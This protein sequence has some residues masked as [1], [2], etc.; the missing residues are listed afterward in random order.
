M[1]KVKHGKWWS[2][3]TS[4]KWSFIPYMIV[5]VAATFV[6][7]MIIGLG[8]NVLQD[9][10][11][12]NYSYGSPPEY[13]VVQTG[14]GEGSDG[15]GTLYLQTGRTVWVAPLY[16][17]LYEAINFVQIL[18]GILWAAVCF[19]IPG[20]LFYKNKLKKPLDVLMSAS[21]QIADNNL[22]FTVEYKSTDEMGALC[23]SFE[24]MRSALEENNLEMWRQMDE[25]K[26]LNAAFS[27][28]LRTPLTVL[29]GQSEMILKYA[30]NGRMDMPKV[31][32]TV[33]TMQR[34]II[35]LEKYT[36]NMNRLQRLE[37]LEIKKVPVTVETLC[38]EL[39]ECGRALCGDKLQFR[40]RCMI[41]G[42]SAVAGGPADAVP[43]D[44]G[45]GAAEAGGPAGAVEAESPADTASG[46]AGGGTTALSLDMELL[47]EVFENLLSNAV[48]YAQGHVCA[49]LSVADGLLLL[50]IADDGPGFSE[51]MLGDAL[52]PFASDDRQGEGQH[53]G[54]GLNICK[55]LCEKHGG[56]IKVYNRDGGCVL[57]ALDA[58]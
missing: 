51:R 18:L 34:H 17:F 24:K 2:N 9:H 8:A 53:F 46:V 55:I 36:E 57:A 58:V 10:L 52:K 40:L 16:K 50:E 32:S 38:R 35:R 25:R 31:I 54:I 7:A 20:A 33:E 12:N 42:E 49:T 4:L 47:M 30:P 43:R 44:A 26:R 45:C 56:Y 29:K 22:D 11:R 28:D 13:E 41:D 15:D 5:M 21:R 23:A 39:K 1:E 37:D 19:I 27:H 6:G 48:R 3:R 14:P